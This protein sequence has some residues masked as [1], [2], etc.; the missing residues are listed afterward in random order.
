MD[1]DKW[2]LCGHFYSLVDPVRSLFILGLGWAM[3]L[4]FVH[5]VFWVELLIQRRLC[6]IFVKITDLGKWDIT[7][8]YRVTRYPQVFRR[9]KVGQRTPG[10]WGVTSSNVIVWG[11]KM[12]LFP[13]FTIRELG[14]DSCEKGVALSHI[15]PTYNLIDI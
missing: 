7:V 4:S 13:C 14:E 1:M 3:L 10:F 2:T 9:L 12:S 5:V 15:R 6:P 8:R 11:N